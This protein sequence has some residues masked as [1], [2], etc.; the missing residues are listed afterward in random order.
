MSHGSA[1]THVLVIDDAP[2]LLALY[3]DLLGNAG[4]R[5]SARSSTDGDLPEIGRL[6]PDVVVLDGRW[7]GDG[8]GWD[9]LRKLKADPTTAAI[10]LVICTFAG[11]QMRARPVKLAAMGVTVVLKPFVPDDLLAAVAAPRGRT[12]GEGLAAAAAGTTDAAGPVEPV[13]LVATPVSQPSAAEKR[14]PRVLP[15]GS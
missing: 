8:A 15:R 10:P 7:E 2:S 5:V 11:R 9:L 6:R 4:Y 13:L 1:R 12:G 3:H 14:G